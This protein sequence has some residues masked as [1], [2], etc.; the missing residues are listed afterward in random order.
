MKN[1]KDL[2]II[3]ENTKQTVYFELP[4]PFQDICKNNYGYRKVELS[5]NCFGYKIT[6][7]NKLMIEFKAGIVP[8]SKTSF[9]AIK[10]ARVYYMKDGKETSMLFTIKMNVVQE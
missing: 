1:F 7:D 10:W 8:K 5:C 9:N 4:F 3:K 6:S 2:G